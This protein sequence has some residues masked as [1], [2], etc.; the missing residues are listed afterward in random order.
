MD[1]TFNE[2]VELWE[3]ENYIEVNKVYLPFEDGV[4]HQMFKEATS[5]R[6]FVFDS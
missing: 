2:R 1:T 6:G 4:V 3:L 5:G